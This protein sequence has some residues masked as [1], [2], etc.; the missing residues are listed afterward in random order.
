M[1]TG[2]EFTMKAIGCLQ[3][4]MQTFVSRTESPADRIRYSDVS[5]EQ[6]GIYHR[7]RYCGSPQDQSQPRIDKRRQ[8]CR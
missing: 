8:A 2:I 7:T 3:C 5:G 4:C 1:N 6:P